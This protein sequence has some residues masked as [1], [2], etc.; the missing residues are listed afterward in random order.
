MGERRVSSKGGC[1]AGQKRC[2]LKDTVVEHRFPK[3]RGDYQVRS[4][5][6]GS[7]PDGKCVPGANP[8]WERREGGGV[9]KKTRKNCWRNGRAWTQ[10]K[11]K[12][13]DLIAIREGG[14]LPP[15]YWS[16]SNNGG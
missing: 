1:C 3:Y 13:E 14:S 2:N 4:S 8:S 5:V 15:K 6:E 10:K 9:P 7:A 16:Y 11:N 12:K